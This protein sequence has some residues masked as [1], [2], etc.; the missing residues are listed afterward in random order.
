MPP[1]TQ[2][3]RAKSI[4]SDTAARQRNELDGHTSK[5]S[6]GFYPRNRRR[7]PRNRLENDLYAS[8]MIAQAILESG[9]GQSRLSQ[10]PYFNLFGIK[11]TYQGQGVAFGHKK[12]MVREITTQSRQLS[13]NILATKSH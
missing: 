13:A 5:R 8:V 1:S 3:P 10:A 2:A 6:V 12:M 9:G 7:C 4:R 11:G